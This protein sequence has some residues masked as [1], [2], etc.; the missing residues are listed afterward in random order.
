VDLITD[1]LVNGVGG[2]GGRALMAG[3]YGMTALLTCLMSN[4]A[5]A[6]LLTPVAID[7]ANTMGLDPRPFVLAIALASSASFMTPI[8]YQTNTMISG[9]GPYKF[10]DFVTI[11]TPLTLLFAVLA[12]FVLPLLWPM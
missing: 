7:P 4:Q 2:F 3:F 5:T 11:G 9:A 8:G 10:R 12:V 1:L 6:V